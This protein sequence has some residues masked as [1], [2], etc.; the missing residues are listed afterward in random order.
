MPRQTKLFLVFS[1]V[2]MLLLG[3]GV[4]TYLFAPQQA[5][6]GTILTTHGTEATHENCASC[7][8]GQQP[9][10]REAFGAFDNDSCMNCHGGAPAT[11]HATDGS[12]A[13]CMN[14]HSGITAAHDSMF[15]FPDTS[16]EDCLLCHAGQ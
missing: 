5:V 8:S 3:Y 9:W 12:F 15:P 2:V 7:H 13:D 10:H 4:R 16:Y 6:G 14:C 1:L 11:P